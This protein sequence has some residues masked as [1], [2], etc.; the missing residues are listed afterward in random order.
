VS[1]NM[2]RKIFLAIVVFLVAL[3]LAG[4][5]SQPVQVS[6]ANPA[7]AESPLPGKKAILSNCGTQ[8]E[9]QHSLAEQAQVEVSTTV[10][11]TATAVKTG[12]KMAIPADLKSQLMVKIQETYQQVIDEARTKV[13]QTILKIPGDRI[14]HYD[15]TWTRQ[16]YSAEVTFNLQNELFTAGY[17]CAVDTP[18]ASFS[19]ELICTG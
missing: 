17:T 15:I 11:D 13:E 3:V 5:S 2:D 1:K 14:H 6:L 10:E 4:C 7:E 18:E 19:A 8:E 12:Q 9:T 16:S